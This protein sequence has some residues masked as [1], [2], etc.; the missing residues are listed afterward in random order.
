MT[1]RLS[2]FE[3]S[4]NKL[5]KIS[6]KKRDWVAVRILYMALEIYYRNQEAQGV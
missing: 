4:T 3:M 5:I 6:A 2:P 1:K